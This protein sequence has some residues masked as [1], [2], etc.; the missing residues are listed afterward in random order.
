[1]EGDD[2]LMIREYFLPLA[3]PMLALA[4]HITWLGDGDRTELFRKAYPSAWEI[5]P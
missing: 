2:I 5:G 4:V 3:C 1:M